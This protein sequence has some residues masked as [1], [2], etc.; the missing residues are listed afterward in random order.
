MADTISKISVAGSVASQWN[1]PVF[2]YKM[3]INGAKKQVDFQDLMIAVSENR[4]TVVEGEVPPLRDRIQQRNTRLERLGSLLSIFTK[5]QANFA[6]DAKGSDSTQVS[7]ITSDQFAEVALAYKKAGMTPPATMTSEWCNSKWS[8]SSIEGMVQALKSTIDGMNNAA[9]TD[10]SRLQSLVDR[11]DES[12]ST[13]T[14]LMT[15]VSD[16]RANLIRNM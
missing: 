12:F 9:Q 6:S 1:I 2:E 8:K 7:G 13:A 5:A 10:M 4:A 16:T 3:D 11:R 15:A 14:N